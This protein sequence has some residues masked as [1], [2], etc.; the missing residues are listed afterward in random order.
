MN[1]ELFAITT[2]K[3]LYNAFLKKV[4]DDILCLGV[5]GLFRKNG[6]SSL[7][8]CFNDALKEV[9]KRHSDSDTENFR[10]KLKEEFFEKG[11][12]IKP[13]PSSSHTYIY[14][15]GCQKFSQFL[16]S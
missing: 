4:V 15:I 2:F 1:I 14:E 5:K 9:M 11:N 6:Y 13:L 12:V 3:A 8:S 16:Y 7:D 10:K